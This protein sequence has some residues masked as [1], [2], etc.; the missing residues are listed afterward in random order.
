MTAR[1]VADVLISFG[2]REPVAVAGEGAATT[3]AMGLD[4]EAAD[5][6]T[7]ET[8]IAA[9]R[10]EGVSEGLARAA[11]ANEAALEA[12]RGAF[13]ARLAAERSRWAR[14]EGHVLA[15]KVTAGLGEIETRIAARAARVL[16]ELLAD[17]LIERAIRELAEHIHA[18]LS[19][20]DGKVVQV[21]GPEDLVAALSEKLEGA[22]AAIDF[23]P[24]AS[25]DVRI[26]CDDTLVES[27]LEAWLARLASLVE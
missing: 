6:E 19:G 9:A 23:R 15:D 24:G 8:A 13:A 10:Q 7:Q 1:S 4:S 26:V 17:R 20:A 5:D 25:A 2:A 12:E 11:A 18:L 14:D 27:R 16:R 3:D 21:T 22:S